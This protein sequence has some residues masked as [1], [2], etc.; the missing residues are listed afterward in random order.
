MQRAQGRAL[1]ATI[2]SRALGALKPASEAGR[3]VREV[4]ASKSCRTII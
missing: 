4:Q 2:K 1:S 3:R